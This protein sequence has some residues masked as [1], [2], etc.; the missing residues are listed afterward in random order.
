MNGAQVRNLFYVKTLVTGG[1]A[2]ANPGDLK[3]INL[4]TKLSGKEAI[5][6]QYVNPLGELIT[7]DFI[8]KDQA[9]CEAVT[10]VGTPL[11]KA[12]LSLVSTP[13]AGEDYIVDILVH[14]YQMLSDNSVLAK[15]GAVRAT[16]SM[17]TSE[18][19]VK[20]AKS[21]A[22]N[23]R[24][25]EVINKFF[26]FYVCAAADV[27]T[28]ANWIEVQFDTVYDAG[29]HGSVDTLIVEEQEQK[30]WYRGTF[31]K[32]TVSFDVAPH[33]I[34]ENGDEVQ[35][36]VTEGESGLVAIVPD[37]TD[38]S[39]SPKTVASIPNG[40]DM[41]DLEYECHGEIGDQLREAGYPNNIRTAYAI[42]D[43]DVTKMFDTV[44]LYFYYVGRNTSPEKAEKQITLAVDAAGA[45]STS[46]ILDAIGVLGIDAVLADHEERIET[47]EE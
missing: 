23:F 33:T 13:V 27:D 7:S 29:T 35:P 37:V 21:F 14:N 39:T 36:F 41:A 1:N 44:E 31:P 25:D 11:K 3:V 12:V 18:F 9:R 19:M 40:Y 22:M 30:T 34:I 5:Q 15:F 6:L 38:G 4:T 47:L 45:V 32:Q 17:A 10:G 28:K 42:S 16:T 26:K 43:A 46:D 2:V 8:I 24:R 20:L